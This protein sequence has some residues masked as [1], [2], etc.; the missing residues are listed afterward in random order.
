MRPRAGSHP[1]GYSPNKRVP[2]TPLRLSDPAAGAQLYNAA[3]AHTA[4]TFQKEMQQR[5]LDLFLDLIRLMETVLFGLRKG[6]Q[7][8]NSE[9]QNFKTSPDSPEPLC[10]SNMEKV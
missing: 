10:V 6:P 4:D 8:A 5:L 2:T 7:K 3:D 1:T 9:L